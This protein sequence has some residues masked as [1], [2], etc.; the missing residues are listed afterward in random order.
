MLTHD[1][2]IANRPRRIAVRVLAWAAMGVLVAGA[3]WA[4][5]T[6]RTGTSG[7]YELRIPVGP[8]GNALGIAGAADPEG[9]DAL[10]YNPAGLSTIGT[11]EAMFS[12]TTYIAGMDINYAAIATNLKN[13]GV[14]AFNAK[15]LS[16]GDVIVT[17]EDAPNG[18]GQ[19]ED[20]T[21]VT[22]GLS[23]AKQF[24]DRVT[25]GTTAN[26]V[27]EH[28]I[29]ASAFGVAFDFG[30]QYLTGWN[31]LNFS[32]AMKNFGPSMQ[33]TGPGF[34]TSVQPPGGDPTAS[35]RTLR[36]TSA[37]F[38][39]PSYFTLGASWDAMHKSN[40]HLILMTAYQN[41]NFS[42]DNICG[43]AEWN[44]KSTLFLRGSYYGSLAENPDPVTGETTVKLTTG[45]DIY[46]GYA[47]GA[48]FNVKTGSAKLGVDAA[49]KPVREFFDDVVEVGVRVIF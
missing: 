41:N 35:P 44:Y 49:W 23:W 34:D 18:T 45:D 43:A 7:A 4:G 33:F 47:I 6:G 10:F 24:S 40:S 8:R 29:D 25:F 17:T 31:G 15:V 9:L 37:S 12:H 2:H 20:P 32:V 3:S 21:F 5:S 1:A 16:L 38:E 28:L 11:T 22:M 39:M 14:L 42:A 13:A 19:I 46:S 27:S 36:S 26:M 30:V 48:G